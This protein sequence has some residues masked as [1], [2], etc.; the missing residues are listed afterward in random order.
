MA[1][2][3]L[4]NPQFEAAGHRRALQRGHI[5][6]GPDDLGVLISSG[7]WG[8]GT[9]RETLELVANQPGLVP[10]VAC[11]RNDGLRRDLERLVG[12]AGY[13]AVVLGW[14]DDMPGVMAACDVLVENAGGLTSLEAMRARLPMVSFRP[15]PGHGRKSAMAMSAAGVSCLA[16]GHTQLVSV[17]RQ[18]G[19]PGPA[20]DAQLTAAARLFA[21]DAAVAVA[22]IGTWG[23]PRPPRLRPLAR[24]VRAAS[25][26]TLLGAI[27]WVG[28]TTGVGVAA[29]A[30]AGVAHP[31]AGQPDTVYVGV[32]LDDQELADHEVRGALLELD[33]SA[34]VDVNTAQVDPGAVRAFASVGINVESGGLGYPPGAAGAPLAPWTMAHS[35]SQSVQVLSAIADEPVEAL[36]PDR[37]L[38]AFDLV[39]AS[40]DHVMMVVPNATL[41]VAPSG[42][43][44]RQDL[45]L[46]Q[47]Q[48]EQIY[49]VNGQAITCDQLIDILSSLR[50]Q[51]THEDLAIAPLDGLR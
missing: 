41:P 32:R 14:T 9:V 36:V 25:A 17:L 42:P 21:D 43:F 18:L 10:V 19:R 24:L 28:M 13:R 23:V 40:V 47:L 37:S 33:A 26:A 39:D 29:A 4:V 2:A 3:P 8:V 38:S 12:T 5:G 34:V 20:R 16:R 1:C 30:G 27:S 49:V 6:L 44:P 22:Q 35:D 50:S 31:P 51:V 45:A 15:I 11:G 46:P 48:A 7:S